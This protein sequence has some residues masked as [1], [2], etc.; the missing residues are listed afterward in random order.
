MCGNSRVSTTISYRNVDTLQRYKHF[1]LYRENRP[2]GHLTH[3]QNRFHT[4]LLFS[5]LRDV[6]VF[7]LLS[8]YKKFLLYSCLSLVTDGSSND[9]FLIRETTYM[10]Y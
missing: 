1:N 6:D 5:I 7:S 10:I 3:E 8:I 4:F 9:S 2:H